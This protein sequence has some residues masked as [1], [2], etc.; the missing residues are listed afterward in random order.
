MQRPNVLNVLTDPNKNIRYE[1]L[2]Y[3]TLREDELVMA[4]R[5][6][7][8]QGKNAPKRDSTITI[9]TLIGLLD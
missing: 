1:V 6:V 9:E 3:R 7:L 4:V 8:S 5:Q 2:A